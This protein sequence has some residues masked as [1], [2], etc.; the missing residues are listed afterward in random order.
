MKRIK[1]NTT[2]TSCSTTFKE[3]MFMA[4]SIMVSSEL[5]QLILSLH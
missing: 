1:V 2:Y 4:V 3:F 5:Q